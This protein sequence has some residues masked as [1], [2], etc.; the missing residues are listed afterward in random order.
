MILMNTVKNMGYIITGYLV[1]ILNVLIMCILIS[2]CDMNHLKYWT[3][4]HNE[5]R[6]RYNRIYILYYNLLIGN[7]ILNGAQMGRL[8]LLSCNVPFI[9]NNS[10]L[11]L[12]MNTIDFINSLWITPRNKCPL[13]I[14][15][16][17][18]SN[19]PI[20]FWFIIYLSDMT[21]IYIFISSLWVS[22]I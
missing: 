6:C 20:L 9:F 7:G 12:K 2:M 21:H 14:S 5:V 4:T 17:F 22:K 10:V 1:H 15:S 18:I 8:N 3:F 11:F 13:L 16:V 19:S